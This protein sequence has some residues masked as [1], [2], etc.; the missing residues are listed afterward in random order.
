MFCVSNK[1]ARPTQSFAPKCLRAE[2]D[3]SQHHVEEG[4]AG[5]KKLTFE[6]EQLPIQFPLVSL[7][8]SHTPVHALTGIFFT[9]RKGIEQNVRSGSIQNI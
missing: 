4:G 6:Q 1:S 9:S 3:L 2:K 7:G 8:I 5:T